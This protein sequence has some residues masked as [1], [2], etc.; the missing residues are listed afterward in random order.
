MDWN[1]AGLVVRYFYMFFSYKYPGKNVYLNFIYFFSKYLPDDDGK[2]GELIFFIAPVSLQLLAN[3][4]FF[5]LTA[6]YCSR[7][8]SEMSE[9]TMGPRS[10]RLKADR[11]M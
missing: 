2:Y 6:R 3:I 11:E 4:V 10:R 9:V 5:V 7:I 8:K 1:H